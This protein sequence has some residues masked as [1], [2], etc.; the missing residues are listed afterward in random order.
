[1]G[2]KYS[3]ILFRGGG[4]TLAHKAVDTFQHGIKTKVLKQNCSGLSHYS[5]KQLSNGRFVLAGP[6]IWICPFVK[7]L[8]DHVGQRVVHGQAQS[9]PLLHPVHEDR[10]EVEV[11]AVD[12]GFVFVP[13]SATLHKVLSLRNYI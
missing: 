12:V 8:C 5:I 4:H 3:L 13:L 2:V 7:E 6:N 11:E 1:M 9:V 10:L